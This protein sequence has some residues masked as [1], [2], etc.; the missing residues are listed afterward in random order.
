MLLRGDTVALNNI[1]LHLKLFVLP[2]KAVS[3]LLIN[4]TV[5]RTLT[6]A[7]NKR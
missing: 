6:R 2:P 3:D 7:K 1:S 5:H 4:Q